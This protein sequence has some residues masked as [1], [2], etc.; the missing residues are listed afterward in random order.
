MPKI[1][2]FVAIVVIAASLCGYAEEIQLKDGTKIEGTL[3]S[4]T[5]DSLSIK[6]AYGEI[7]V[8]RTEVLTITFPQNQP[9]NSETNGSAGLPSVDDS[10]VGS[11]YT[12]RTAHFQLTLVDG[13]RLAPDMRKSKDIV[14]S[15]TSADKTLFF[16]VT[17]EDFVGTFATYKVL[18]ETQYQT[19][20]NDYAKVSETEI[21]LDGRNATKLIF[22]GTPSGQ[23]T[24]LKF[25][26]Y[27]VPYDG[28]MV[29][30]T[31][32]TLE[33][34]FSNALPVFE[35]IANSYKSTDA[36]SLTKK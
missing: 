28:R 3:L 6:T 2:P 14:A 36:A 21:R 27:V 19:K 35:A 9:K 17:P 10:L 31:F 26:V 4:V 8:P 15:F 20:F 12:N 7:K 33:P 1:T 34:L 18:A 32:L 16:L 23:T 22:T 13:W 30:L 25:L 5:A 11:S 24:R 29:R